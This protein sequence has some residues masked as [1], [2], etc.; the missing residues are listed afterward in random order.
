MIKVAINGFGRIGRCTLKALLK[1]HDIV[2]KAINDTSNIDLIC[3]LLKYDSVHGVCNAGI[4]KKDDNTLTINNKDIKVYSDR[5]PENLPWGDLGIDVVIESTGVFRTEKLASKHIKAGA[6]RVITSAPLKEG[7][8]PTIV[9]GVNENI[10]TKKEKIISN[11]SCT[12]NCLAPI[13]KVLDKNFGIETGFL[14]TIHSFTSD[15]NLHDGSHKDFRRA[16]AATSSIIPTTSGAAKTTAL[17]FPHLEGKLDGLAMRVPVINGS[18]VDFTT[19]IKTPNVSV[20][21]INSAFKQATVGTLSKVLKYEQDPIVS[22]D[23][24]GSPYSCIFDSNLTSTNGLLIK[25]IGWYDNEAGYSNRLAD[26][27]EYLHSN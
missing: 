26:L 21:D 17:I 13:V 22:V 1:K 8:A 15:Q 4:Y 9:M 18:V 3:Y 7:Y 6:K 12:T 5:N 23:I 20:N 14:N 24:I 27:V 16:R 10:L 2:V 11:A 25:V 19:T